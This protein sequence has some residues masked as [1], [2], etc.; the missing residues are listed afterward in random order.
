MPRPLNTESGGPYT[1]S[2]LAELL[3]NDSLV[4]FYYW[5]GNSYRTSEGFS[6]DQYISPMCRQKS[7]AY[8]MYLEDVE[9]GSDRVAAL[10]YS[11]DYNDLTGS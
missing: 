7:E 5:L 9:S 11:R 1:S 10:I 2:Q 6:Q 8:Q 3:S 4:D